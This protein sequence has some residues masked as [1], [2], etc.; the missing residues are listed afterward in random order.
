M[1]KSFSDLPKYPEASRNQGMGMK[2]ILKYIEEEKKYVES[3]G[4][5]LELNP[6][7]QRG[8]VW[9]ESQQSKYMEHVLKGG[10]DGKIISFN[11]PTYCIEEQNSNIQCI[12]G[13]QRLTAIR[14]FFNNEIKVFGI[15]W[16]NFDKASKRRISNINFEICIYTYKT[17]KEILEHYLQI[18][19]G[20][21]PHSLFEIERVRKILRDL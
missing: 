6:D 9:S 16:E 3:L 1:L 12:D 10:L 17:K 20:G 4:Y 11:N 15:A 18:N 19:E 5:E 8:H 13:L 21:T 7:F 14:K 2:H